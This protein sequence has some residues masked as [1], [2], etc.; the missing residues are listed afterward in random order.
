MLFRITKWH[1]YKQYYEYW[2]IHYP[3]ITLLWLFMLLTPFYQPT[4]TLRTKQSKLF[5]GCQAAPLS[6][7]ASP[8]TYVWKPDGLWIFPLSIHYIETFSLKIC[9]KKI[10]TGAWEKFRDLQWQR[11]WQWEGEWCLGWSWSEL[12]LSSPGPVLSTTIRA[13]V[14]CGVTPAQ[15]VSTLQAPVTTET[16]SEAA[17]HQPPDGEQWW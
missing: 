3:H 13:G 12:R 11:Q 7:Q 8:S 9:H 4:T 14:E 6:Y 16:S 5:I 10:L 2:N 17:T 15:S 1:N